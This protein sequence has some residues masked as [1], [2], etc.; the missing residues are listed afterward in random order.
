[1][2]TRLVAKK[3][4]AAP[5]QRTELATDRYFIAHDGE[6]LGPLLWLSDYDDPTVGVINDPRLNFLHRHGFN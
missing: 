1:M 4:A 6:R 5:I 3:R 2:M